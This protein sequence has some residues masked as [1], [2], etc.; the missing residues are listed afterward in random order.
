VGLLE[1][2]VVGRRIDLHV[3]VKT[4]LERASVSRG[5]LAEKNPRKFASRPASAAALCLSEPDYKL[6][7]RCCSGSSSEEPSACGMSRAEILVALLL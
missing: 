7:D 2:F 1:R 5:R 6:I 4:S 3:A